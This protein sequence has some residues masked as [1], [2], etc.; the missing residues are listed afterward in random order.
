MKKLIAV[1]LI[2]LAVTLLVSCTHEDADTDTTD[3]STTDALTTTEA[4][5]T[6]APKAEKLIL[7]QDKQTDFKVIRSEEASGYALDTATIVYRK[8]AGELSPDF[9]F[10]SDFRS[11]LE[12]DPTTAH[13]ILLFSTER[14]ES[15]AAMADL[16]FEGYII[17]V[18]DC[19]VV[20]VGSSPASC[21]AAL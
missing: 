16:T 18:T 11:P 12:P 3:E 8:L 9:R 7:V 6:E 10:A 2:I 4:A 17:R 1:F 19:K 21:N 14:A 5:E 13:E 15:V 20:I